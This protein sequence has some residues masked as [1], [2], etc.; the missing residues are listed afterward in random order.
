MKCSNGGAYIQDGDLGTEDQTNKENAME[1]T[2]FVV[3]CPKCGE[4]ITRGYIEERVFHN[5]LM[6]GETQVSE[7]HG[8]CPHCHI[9][10]T[11]SYDGSED[12]SYQVWKRWAE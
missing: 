4:S 6:F 1:Y 3:L 9:P 8:E 7:K 11:F 10:L 5:N 12:E 2:P